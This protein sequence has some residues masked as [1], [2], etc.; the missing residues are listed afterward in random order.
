MRWLA[1]AV[2]CTPVAAEA[3]GNAG[4]PVAPGLY[5]HDHEESGAHMVL[6]EL[7]SPEISV[8]VVGQ[9][10]GGVTTSEVAASDPTLVAVQSGGP[11]TA[12]GFLAEG[13]T[14]SDGAAWEGTSD[15]ELTPVLAFTSGRCGSLRPSSESTGIADWFATALSGATELLRDGQPSADLDCSGDLCE[16]APRSA[17]GVSANG[18]RLIQ[19]V[20]DG[21]PGPGAGT[22]AAE[23]ADLMLEHG[24]YAAM[25]LEGGASAALT[26]QG[27]LVSVPSDGVER[28]VGHA[29]AV[30]RVPVDDASKHIIVGIAFADFVGGNRRI[31]DPSVELET[32]SGFSIPNAE[33][34][35]DSGGYFESIRVLPRSY[36]LLVGA[37]GF[38]KTCVRTADD[39]STLDVCGV[40][41]EPCRWSSV[42]LL[43][44]GSGVV[45]CPPIACGPPP[46]LEEPP[47]GGADA[48]TNGEPPGG[49]GSGCDCRVGAGDQSPTGL[50][51]ALAFA[52]LCAAVAGPRR[53]RS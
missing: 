32:L 41:E 11:F 44:G 13:L 22:T 12:A 39:P 8:V 25:L 2:L 42:R 38:A 51:C 52:A 9:G 20:V 1:L 34:Y 30:R 43:E 40:D 4:D 35:S 17:I 31:A 49:S 29:V 19:V 5:R 3:H 48:G 36:R 15:D 23:L 10:A 53:R 46:D 24:A 26:V 47:C 50:Q 37:A 16:A 27:S 7:D 21:P 18:Y 14:V 45:G 28:E 33:A 6:T